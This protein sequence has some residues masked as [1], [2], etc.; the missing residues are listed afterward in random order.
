MG[1]AGMG[2]PGG[3]SCALQLVECRDGWMDERGVL[4]MATEELVLPDEPGQGRLFPASFRIEQEAVAH[5]GFCVCFHLLKSS[6]RALQG[7]EEASDL[8]GSR[9][10]CPQCSAFAAPSAREVASFFPSAELW[11]LFLL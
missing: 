10:I 8:G 4:P 6:P 3:L 7:P 11:I 1:E 5:L 2:Q 9:M